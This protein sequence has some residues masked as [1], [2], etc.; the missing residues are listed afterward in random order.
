MGFT[1]FDGVNMNNLVVNTLATVPQVPVNPTDAASKA[2]VDTAAA[3]GSLTNQNV[4]SALQATLA[5]TSAQIKAL[6]ATPQTVIPA[7]AAGKAIQILGVTFSYSRLTADYTNAG[8]DL[9]LKIGA[10]EVVTGSELTAVITNAGASIAKSLTPTDNAT[11]AAATAL[12]LA[13]A[14]NEFAAG[15]G[16]AKLIVTYVVVTL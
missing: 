2:Y 4:S 10:Q 6:L 11:L 5:L 7:P 1:H 16:T 13:K 15:S 14:T 12:V 9:S 3:G 8:G